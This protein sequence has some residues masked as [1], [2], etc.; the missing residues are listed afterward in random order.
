MVEVTEALGDA[1]RSARVSKTELAERLG[2]SKSFVSQ[3][4]GGGRNLTLRTL[5]DV[6]DA[7]GCR[8]RV[9]LAPRKA[10]GR[11]IQHEAWRK[12]QH[13]LTVHVPELPVEANF[14]EDCA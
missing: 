12:P 2:R 6:A 4:L 3:V 5:A 7:L 11:V 14:M 1:L 10:S 9:L 13:Q 8:V